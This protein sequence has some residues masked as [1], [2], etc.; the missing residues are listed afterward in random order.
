MRLPHRL[1][2]Q[3]SKSRG[4][5]ILWRP[6]SRTA[7]CY[8]CCRECRHNKNNNNNNNNNKQQQQSAIIVVELFMFRLCLQGTTEARYVATMKTIRQVKTVFIIF[9]AFVCCWSPY[10]VVLLYDYSDILPL[11]VHMYT[12]MLAHLHAS[13]NFAIYGLSN[14]TYS[15]HY[16]RSTARILTCFHRTTPNNTASTVFYFSCDTRRISGREAECIRGL[17]VN[18]PL[19]AVECQQSREMDGCHGAAAETS[20][21][22]R[23]P[24]SICTEEEHL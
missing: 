8:Y 17:D 21:P 4:G 3:K 16:Q 1:Q 18:V 11:S 7:C 14:R 22:S 10:I 2:G 19:V 5:G 15:A 12:S 20:N 23:P 9:I 13:L 24:F 6:P